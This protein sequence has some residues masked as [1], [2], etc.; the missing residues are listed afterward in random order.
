[1]DRTS[2]PRSITVCTGAGSWRGNI[3]DPL[4]D[5]TVGSP[6]AAVAG[7]GTARRPCG[8][9]ITDSPEGLKA[10]RKSA[11]VAGVFTSWAAG[12]RIARSAA[13]ASG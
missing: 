7:S 5:G 8:A 2:D 9:E 4:A 1:M 11:G 12:R 3:S 13:A 10:R 6:G